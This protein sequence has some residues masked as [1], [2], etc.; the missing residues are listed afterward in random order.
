MIQQQDFF[1]FFFAKKEKDFWGEHHH[2]SSVSD[3]PLALLF[4]PLV[5]E[6][7]NIFFAAAV[8]PNEKYQKQHY[9]QITSNQKALSP[10]AVNNNPQFTNLHTFVYIIAIKHHSPFS[11]SYRCPFKCAKVISLVA[12][13][14]LLT[15]LHQSHIVVSL[16]CLS[17]STS[18]FCFFAWSY[19]FSKQTSEFDK[20]FQQCCH[21]ESSFLNYCTSFVLFHK[22]ILHILLWDYLWQGTGIN[23][24]THTIRQRNV[25]S[26][27]SYFG[28][29][30]LS[31]GGYIFFQYQILYF[32]M[33]PQVSTHQD[34]HCL[35]ISHL[36]RIVQSIL[37]P[38]NHSFSASNQDNFS[39]TESFA[40]LLQNR[41]PTNLLLS[42]RQC[43]F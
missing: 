10:H 9:F 23:K 7:F 18:T 39:N 8:P 42:I 22:V 24:L 21:Q 35:S 6:F 14:F 26:I 20:T 37:R 15:S 2:V 40:I 12:N 1:F 31:L 38:S 11:I 4:P 17:S 3:I 5:P 30:F 27:F 25:L 34:S 32:S 29:S 13:F 16:L 33:I 28:G 19:F 36:M 43:F 41:L